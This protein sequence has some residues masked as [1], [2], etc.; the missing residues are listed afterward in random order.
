[1]VDFYVILSFIGNNCTQRNF[2]QQFVSFY[3]DNHKKYNEFK[4]NQ[5]AMATQADK[6]ELFFVSKDRKGHPEEF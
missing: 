1:M 5:G 2:S 6:N 3:K 4:K